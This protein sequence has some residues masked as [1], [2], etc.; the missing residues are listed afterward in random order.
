ML[1]KELLFWILPIFFTSNQIVSTELPLELTDEEMYQLTSVSYQSHFTEIPMNPN[2]AQTIHTYKDKELTV[3]DTVIQPNQRFKIRSLLVNHQQQQV[4]QLDNNRYILAD[5]AVVY[6][7]VIVKQEFVHQTYWLAD[8]FTVYSSPIE[9]QAKKIKTTLKPYQSVVVTEIANSHWGSFAKIS[10]VGWI[11]LNQLSEEDNRIEA[12][13]KLLNQHYQSDKFS[14]YV[15]QLSTDKTATINA[16]KKMYAAS[17]SKLPVLYYSQKQIDEGKYRL[18]QGLQYVDK[19]TSFKGSYS[20]EGSG[21]LSKTADNKQY[22]IAQLMD[23]TSK[24]SD[25]AASNVLAYY[26][27]NQFDEAFY[28]DI[29]DITKEKWDMQ[30]RFASSKMAG[31]MMEAIYFQKGYALQSLTGT[32]FDNQ[33]IAKAIPVKISHK[34]GDAYDVKHDVAVVYTDSPFILSIF[35][36]GSDYDTISQIAKD[37][38]GILK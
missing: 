24:Y 9:N 18:D 12:V 21:I 5:T 4:F 11:K 23:L 17:I 25:N 14:I 31:L 28:S 26:L 30:T 20:P 22:S 37:V 7:D 3:V 34:I 13:Q 35:T 19:V 1:K 10:N 33:R 36:D 29:T 32:N 38:Y 16:E 6:D 8:N 27:T 15:K 2:V